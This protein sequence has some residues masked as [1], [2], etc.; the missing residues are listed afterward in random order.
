[1][2]AAWGKPG[3]LAKRGRER[4]CLAKAQAQADIGDRECKSPQQ[5]LGALNSAMRMIPVRRHAERLLE[6]AAEMVRA[7]PH[8][9]SQSCK[10]YLLRQMVLYVRGHEP[11]LPSREPSPGGSAVTVVAIQPKHLMHEHRAECL[12]VGQVLAGTCYQTRELV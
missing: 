8:K 7:Q 2:V 1:M 6:R 5:N 10:R 12:K 3:H 4:A 9:A 11:P